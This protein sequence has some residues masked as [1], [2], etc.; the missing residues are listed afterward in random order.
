MQ[1]VSPHA[2]GYSVPLI[3]HRGITAANLV[4]EN[5]LASLFAVFAPSPDLLSHLMHISPSKASSI[6]GMCLLTGTCLLTSVSPEGTGFAGGTE[7]RFFGAKIFTLP[8]VGRTTS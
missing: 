3:S 6:K 5:L 2:S 8:K 7:G 1:V 4:I